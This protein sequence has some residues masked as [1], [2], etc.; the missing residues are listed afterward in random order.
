[1]LS[2]PNVLVDFLLCGVVGQKDRIASDD[3]YGCLSAQQHLGF[4]G[5]KIL[6]SSYYLGLTGT[7]ASQGVY[8]VGL[9][10]LQLSGCI[11]SAHWPRHVLPT[12]SGN[13]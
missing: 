2:L 9:P 12:L 10:L 6:T 3:H 8:A 11:H 7:V 1:M 13:V 5:V 4:P